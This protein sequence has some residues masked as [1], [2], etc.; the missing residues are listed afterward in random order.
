MKKSYCLAYAAIITAGALLLT[1]SALAKSNTDFP[2]GIIGSPWSAMRQHYT[3][4]WNNYPNES[5]WY[6]ARYNAVFSNGTGLQNA[7][8][9]MDSLNVNWFYGDF[10]SSDFIANLG[11]SDYFFTLA[12]D[13][14]IE[15]SKYLGAERMLMDIG[16]ERPGVRQSDNEQLALRTL[17]APGDTFDVGG[18]SRVL[19]VG[20]R[21]QLDP[22]L[23]DGTSNVIKATEGTH[24]PGWILWPGDAEKYDYPED[25]SRV[26]QQG[27][28]KTH[29]RSTGTNHDWFFG[30]PD[31]SFTSYFFDL[32]CQVPSWVDTSSCDTLAELFIFMYSYTGGTTMPLD[33]NDT[34]PDSLRTRLQTVELNWVDFCSIPIRLCDFDNPGEFETVHKLD[35]LKY[36]WPNGSHMAIGLYW[37]GIEDFSVAS[38]DIREEY[39]DEL[40]ELNGAPKQKFNEVVTTLSGIPQQMPGAGFQQD[41][42]SWNQ[43]F[44][45]GMFNR[46]LPNGITINDD[47]VT[48]STAI[49]TVDSTYQRL[50]SNDQEYMTGGWAR[51]TPHTGTYVKTRGYDHW[52]DDDP[53]ARDGFG[54]GARP[55][56]ATTSELSGLSNS[57]AVVANIDTCVLSLQAYWDLLID[58]TAF[59]DWAIAD[60]QMP[61]FWRRRADAAGSLLLH[62]ESARNSGADWAGY[63]AHNKCW[64]NDSLKMYWYT[65]GHH[66]SLTIA[67]RYHTVPEMWCQTGLNLAYGAKGIVWAEHNAFVFE[68]RP[69]AWEATSVHTKEPWFTGLSKLYASLDTVGPTLRACRWDNSFCTRSF[70]DNFDY[71]YAG[72]G[73]IAIDTVYTKYWNDTPSLDWVSEAA[74]H[75]YVQ[76]STFEA[77]NSV[78]DE[79]YL[80]LVNRRCEEHERRQIYFTLD[81]PQASSEYRCELARGDSSWIVMTDEEGKASFM[82]QLPPGEYELFHVSPNEDLI[83]SDT[84]YTIYAPYLLNRNIRIRNGGE[85]TIL[86]DTSLSA[87]DTAQVTCWPGKGVY[88]D[89]G[90]GNKFNVLGT[91][92][93]AIKFRALNGLHDVDNWWI[94][95]RAADTTALDTVTLQST[96]IEHARFG[97]VCRAEDSR[98]NLMRSAVRHCLIGLVLDDYATSDIRYS[99]F[100][101]NSAAIQ[102]ERGASIDVVK[103]SILNCGSG[104][105]LL[106]NCT[107]S[108]KEV[109]VE[110]SHNGD[111]RIGT[112]GIFGYNSTIMMK[113]CTI[114]SNSCDGLEMVGGTLIIADF[115]TSG[116]RF[117]AN[118]FFENNLSELR[119]DGPA[120]VWADSG[121]NVFFE[122]STSDPL[123]VRFSNISMPAYWRANYWNGLTADTTIWL[124][125]GSLIEDSLGVPLLP[126]CEPAFPSEPDYC[127]LPLRE[128]TLT[129]CIIEALKQEFVP[130][131][132]AAS[133]LYEDALESSSTN[134]KKTPTVSRLL[135]VNHFGGVDVSTTLS[136]LF[137][138]ADTAS[139]DE[140]LH[141]AT[142]GMAF[143]LAETDDNIDSALTLYQQ[144][145]ESAGEDIYQRIDGQIGLL[146]TS[147]QK[148]AQDTCDGMTDDEYLEYL[149]S[150][151]RVFGQRFVWT[152]YEIT[153]SV[154][155][156]APMRVDSVINVRGD[157][158]LTILPH[159]GYKN[160]VVEFV[161]Q[162][163]IKVWGTDSTK[164]KGKLYVYGDAE[165]RVKLH[166]VDSTGTRNIKSE[167]GL[168]KMRHANF[169]GNGMANQTSD[170]AGSVQGRRRATLQLDSCNFSWFEDGVLAWAT[171]STSYMRAC[172]LTHVGGSQFYSGFGAALT[173]LKSDSFKVED[174]VFSESNGVSIYQALA[175]G[176]KIKNSII[177][178]GA[179][180][181]I[182][183]ASSGGGDARIECCTLVSN[184]DTLAELYTL[185]VIY[186]LVGGHNS[187]ADSSGPLIKS[188]DPSYVDL[189]NG[190]NYFDVWDDGRYLQSGDTN[191]TWDITWNTWSPAMPNDSNFYDYLWPAAP[192]NWTVDSSLTDFLTCGESATSSIGGGS[193][194]VLDDNSESGTMSTGGDE[195]SKVSSLNQK[196]AAQTTKGGVASKAREYTPNH[197]TRN[198]ANAYATRKQAK[199]EKLAHHNRELLAW[200]DMRSTSKSNDKARAAMQFLTDHQGSEFTPAALGIIAG[201]ASDGS[202]VLASKY[203]R[204][205]AE[206]TKK[207]S[208]RT[209]AQR[210]SYQALAN[211]GK[212]AEALSGLEDMMTDAK[213]PYDSVLAVL[214][215]MQIYFDYHHTGRLQAR[216]PQVVVTDPYD[217][218]RK[219]LLLTERLDDPVL[220]VSDNQP[221][222]PTKY[223]LYQNYPNPFNPTTEIRFDLPEAIRVELKVFNILGQEV[224]TLVDEVRN[225][226]AYRVLWDGKNLGGQVTASGVY[227]YQLKTPTFTDA[228]KMVLIR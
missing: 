111:A 121:Y 94:G 208:L 177:S 147:I 83:I 17:W 82:V 87:G 84:T 198:S 47:A 156:Y 110:K 212:P 74:N 125:I 70:E 9:H 46:H 160:P 138:I 115:D 168:V 20:S 13:I 162:G 173:L 104:V 163:A 72:P 19:T 181:G 129:D 166:W 6:E 221:A 75:T 183:G 106:N 145:V 120:V 193:W 123:W 12:E 187:F 150:L 38:L 31:E 108:L 149:D 143:L 216:H 214:A 134:C 119:V 81:M 61:S 207:H 10:V 226:G 140:L 132:S 29:C 188:A 26:A 144:V 202:A 56:D 86:P 165:N 27:T 40:F 21:V 8:S 161:E 204:G 222:L 182:W 42:P 79:L 146:M 100:C 55:P 180:Y 22:P 189:E 185:G 141:A 49:W 73:G 171:D 80:F 59:L 91:D 78:D 25:Y 152:Q 53:N 114:D 67:N 117:G 66:D 71:P 11:R 186:D 30:D 34:N 203:L 3:E 103:T 130:D 172:T 126:E 44:T 112:H 225:A 96:L 184:G 131:L 191:N 97:I 15:E 155:M 158:V 197:G 63:I 210:L 135:P 109:R 51:Q 48:D 23:P 37:Y 209:L 41:E 227:V 118:W 124:H 101:F 179:T 68:D 164:E 57:Y 133:V 107:A 190:E 65:G 142:I 167:R 169:Y 157:G 85:L 2:K 137:S 116:A 76:V 89:E 93:N 45:L 195:P 7:I 199:L 192:A 62:A 60:G 154:V 228:K 43:W 136:Y 98:V 1:P 151:N 223:A 170:V 218:V 95:I 39:Y 159:P 127:Y 102:C 194:L 153:D 77:P 219:T 128:P 58:N 69:L 220:G 174:C 139:N 92:S 178:N 205:F 113:C 16:W 64:E 122:D 36:W 33:N 201:A 52:Y 215:A 4:N 18:T 211:E 105:K 99:T 90:I 50:T 176:V 54:F 24:N 196:E 14:P 175:Y 213:T 88:L 217:L 32:L 148:A 35:S 200:R 206:E 28:S 224:A 5:A